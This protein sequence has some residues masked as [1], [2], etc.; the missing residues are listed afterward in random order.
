MSNFNDRAAAIIEAAQA[1]AAQDL[2]DWIENSLPNLIRLIPADERDKY[3]RDKAAEL[4]QWRKSNY[5]RW[6]DLPKYGP[7]KITRWLCALM[8]DET[9]GYQTEIPTD[10]KAVIL[11]ANWLKVDGIITHIVKLLNE[12]PPKPKEK[13]I[14]GDDLA[15]IIRQALAQKSL[16]SDTGA[17]IGKPYDV[18]ALYQVLKQRGYILGTAKEPEKTF[19][20]FFK[21]YFQFAVS[22]RALRTDE[23]RGQDES[24]N[25]FLVI[26]PKK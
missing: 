11:M 1:K 26:I 16:L 19:A 18:K 3:L 13:Q 10:I 15:A 17:F 6:L 21:Q 14:F 8:R 7:E 22:D 24:R 5:R 25:D 23:T 2:R 4:R 20:I 9:D 12:T